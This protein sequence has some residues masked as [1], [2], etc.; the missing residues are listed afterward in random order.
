M[1]T[2][3]INSLLDMMESRLNDSHKKT[4]R[5]IELCSDADFSYCILRWYPKIMN[6]LAMELVREVIL[7]YPKYYAN[8]Q[9]LPDG[10]ILDF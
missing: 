6:R 5:N 2:K 8:L 7:S 4:T 9:A 10:C 1:F 3:D